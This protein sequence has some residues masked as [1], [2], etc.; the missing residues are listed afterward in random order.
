LT[1][2][3][4]C[5]LQNRD[6]RSLTIGKHDFANLERQFQA[7]SDEKTAKLL[8]RAVQKVG[9][10]LELSN[11]LNC[12]LEQSLPTI[13]A[14]IKTAAAAKTLDKVFLIPSYPDNEG[15]LVF[16]YGEK[17]DNDR[18]CQVITE[19]GQCKT[20]N[21]IID[22]VKEDIRS[23]ADLE[24]VLLDA[25]LSEDAMTALFQ[26]LSPTEFAALKKHYPKTY[27]LNIL[28]ENERRLYLALENFTSSL[29]KMQQTYLEKIIKQMNC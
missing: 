25:D 2:A 24:D 15:K 12:Y 9:A 29:P 6:I 10:D 18:Y 4:A 11:D 26:L 19:M 21:D 17:M 7:A 1:A 3:L 13:A 27:D 14:S 22:V 28:R 23:L 20:V 16:T 5:A 8:H